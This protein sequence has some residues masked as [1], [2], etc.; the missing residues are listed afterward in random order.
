MTALLGEAPP[1]PSASGEED[2]GES[3][4]YRAGGTNPGNF[5]IRP[6]ETGVSFR[7]SLSNP[8]DSRSNPPFKSGPYVVVDAS[9]LPPE[10]LV[11]DDVPPGH[12]SVTATPEQIRAAIIDRGKLP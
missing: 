5:K 8:I 6:R 11:Y 12:V 4:I 10:S 1:P 9:K 3:L 7:D 2:P